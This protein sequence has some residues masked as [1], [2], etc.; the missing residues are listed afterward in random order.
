[1]PIKST[2]KPF[3]KFSLKCYTNSAGGIVVLAQ[4]GKQ[5]HWLFNIEDGQICFDVVYSKAALAALQKVGFTF[6]EDDCG[7][8]LRV[9]GVSISS[10]ELRNS[11]RLITN[12]LLETE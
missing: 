6:E 2:L 12:K 3:K 7:L 9:Q 8:R 11:L 1:M 5:E 4:I 10:E